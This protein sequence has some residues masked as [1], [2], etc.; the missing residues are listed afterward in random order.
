[1]SSTVSDHPSSAAP[2]LFL[3]L[4]LTQRFLVRLN[5]TTILSR[6]EENR[7]FVMQTVQNVFPFW[8]LF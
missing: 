8:L 3:M 2:K 5:L 7:L 6:A 1:M 4:S